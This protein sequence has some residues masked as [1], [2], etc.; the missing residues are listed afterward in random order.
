MLYRCTSP[1]EFPEVNPMQQGELE[2]V[3]VSV[4]VSN[5]GCGETIVT[6]GLGVL[7]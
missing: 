5:L 2:H 6:E 3:Q 1:I 4:P 7:N